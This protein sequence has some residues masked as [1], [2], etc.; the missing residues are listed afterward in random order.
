[1]IRVS[2]ERHCKLNIILMRLHLALTFYIYIYIYIYISHFFIL[3]FK[4]QTLQ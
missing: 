4:I 2:R 1:M 3:K